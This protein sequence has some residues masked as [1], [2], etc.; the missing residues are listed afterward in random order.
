MQMIIVVLV[1]WGHKWYVTNR[2]KGIGVFLGRGRAI[3]ACPMDPLCQEAHGEL[4][5]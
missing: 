3:L 1:P 2:I 5:T 4:L